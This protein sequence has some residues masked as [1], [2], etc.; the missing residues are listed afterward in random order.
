[1]AED[2]RCNSKKTEGDDQYLRLSSDLHKCTTRVPTLKHM[3]TI[4]TYIHEHI[5]I[6]HTHM[7]AHIH[8]FFKVTYRN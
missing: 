1:M 4:H 7:H 6:L 3:H 5:L 8:I 2:K